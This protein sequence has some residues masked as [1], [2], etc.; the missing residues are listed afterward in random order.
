MWWFRNGIEWT[1]CSVQVQV[2]LFKRFLVDINAQ[3]GLGF[4]SGLGG[5]E[6]THTDGMHAASDAHEM[7]QILTA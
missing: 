1:C 3:E 7:V 6:H 5:F 4:P 2:W